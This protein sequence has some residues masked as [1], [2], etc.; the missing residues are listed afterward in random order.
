[1]LAATANRLQRRPHVAIARHQ[2]PAGRNKVAGLNLAA[3]VH[4]FWLAFA[5]VFERPRPGDVSVTFYHCVRAAEINGFLR[6][7]SG[8]NSAENHIRS[9]FARDL[10]NFVSAQSVGRMNANADRIARLNALRIHRKQRFVNQNR[11]SKTSRRGGSQNVLPSRRDYCGSKRHTTWV[12]Q[13]N[14]HARRSLWFAKEQPTFAL[15]AT[16]RVGL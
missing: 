16:D 11:I 8:V 12:D 13:V 2:V 5:A 1:M 7:K 6:I 14:V 4:W 9:P 3:H 15:N 10:A